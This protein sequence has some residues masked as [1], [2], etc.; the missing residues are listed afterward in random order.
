M[1]N[2]FLRRFG[3]KEKTTLSDKIL[4]EDIDTYYKKYN[5][6]VKLR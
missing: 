1:P 6:K 4:K 5:F 2:G 3:I